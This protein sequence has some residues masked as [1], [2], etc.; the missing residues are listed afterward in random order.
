MVNFLFNEY[1]GMKLKDCVFKIVD[2]L[3]I[4]LVKWLIYI[5]RFDDKCVIIK[6][7]VK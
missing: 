7:F 1:Y 3:C 2:V 5:V 4:L 6:K